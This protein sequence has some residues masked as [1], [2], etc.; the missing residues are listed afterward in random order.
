MI[1]IPWYSYRTRVVDLNKCHQQIKLPLSFYTCTPITE[2]LSN[3][4]TINNDINILHVFIK[5][6]VLLIR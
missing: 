3:M 2:L 1:I 4:S 6:Y 5:V